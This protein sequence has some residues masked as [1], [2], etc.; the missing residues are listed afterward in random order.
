MLM[1][2]R[3]DPRAPAV[4][5]SRNAEQLVARRWHA[6]LKAEP[7]SRRFAF[8]SYAAALNAEEAGATKLPSF[9]LRKAA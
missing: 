2:D 4:E 5:V 9:G 1:I 3:I 6:F 7:E 8:A